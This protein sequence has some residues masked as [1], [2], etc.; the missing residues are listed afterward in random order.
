MAVTAHGVVTHHMQVTNR[1]LNL[2]NKKHSHHA[3]GS[4]QAEIRESK[5]KYSRTMTLG[6]DRLNHVSQMIGTL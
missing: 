6:E 3:E 2:T 1:D 5:I 4:S